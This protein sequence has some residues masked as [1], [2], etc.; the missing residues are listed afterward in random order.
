MIHLLREVPLTAAPLNFN[1]DDYYLRAAVLQWNLN[2]IVGEMRALMYC[3]VGCVQN[4]PEFLLFNIISR[5]ASEHRDCPVSER[6]ARHR[7]E[8]TA[9]ETPV[10]NGYEPVT[11]QR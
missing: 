6:L 9:V 2:Q 1:V 10:R 4:V 3:G 11:L 5:F 8:I 7:A